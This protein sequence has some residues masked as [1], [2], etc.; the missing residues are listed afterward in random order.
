MSKGKFIIKY[1][2]ENEENIGYK[3]KQKGDARPVSAILVE[4]L[5]ESAIKNG[6][7]KSE[8]INK[9]KM[10]WDVIKEDVK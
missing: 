9:I 5:L 8:F 2:M 1:N 4:I 7:T 3:I 6:M 10:S